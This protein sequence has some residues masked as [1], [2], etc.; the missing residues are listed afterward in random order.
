MRE[1]I[2]V[3]EAPGGIFLLKSLRKRRYCTITVF[4]LLL[5]GILFVYLV[6][7]SETT[8]NIENNLPETFQQTFTGNGSEIPTFIF[9]QQNKTFTNSATDCNYQDINRRY[10]R[11]INVTKIKTYDYNTSNIKL[12]FQNI[13]A[14]NFQKKVENNVPSDY[15][16]FFINGPLMQIRMSIASK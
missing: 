13:T 12:T 15:E 7:I 9:G 3:S 8:D 6:P 11:F 16:K 4:L 5:V 10:E 14:Y 1:R 2:Q